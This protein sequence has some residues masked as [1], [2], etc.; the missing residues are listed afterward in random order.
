V[1]LLTARFVLLRRHGLMANDHAE[2]I[3][4]EKSTTLIV[5]LISILQ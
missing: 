1:A 2:E 3:K 4:P 5:A